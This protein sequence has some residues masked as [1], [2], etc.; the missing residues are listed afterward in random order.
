MW[1]V[2]VCHADPDGGRAEFMRPPAEC[3]F[4]AHPVQDRRDWPVLGFAVF[5]VGTLHAAFHL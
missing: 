4:D 5:A 3:A 2:A 1:G